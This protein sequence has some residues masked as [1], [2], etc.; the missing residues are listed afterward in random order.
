MADDPFM[1]FIMNSVGGSHDY[2][3]QTFSAGD[4][5]YFDS[6]E[7]YFST[8]DFSDQIDNAYLDAV[9]FSTTLHDYN[10]DLTNDTIG[11]QIKSTL[12]TS[13]S[14]QFTINNHKLA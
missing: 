3:S 8:T 2:T 14:M 1:N 13:S 7:N 9:S 6:N 4:T 5:N 11:V 10:S 12:A